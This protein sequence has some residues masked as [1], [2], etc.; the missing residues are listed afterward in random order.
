MTGKRSLITYRASHYRLDEQHRVV[1]VPIL[2]DD[3]LFTWAR[4][5]FGADRHVADTE[6]APGIRV[7]TVFLGLDHRF[8][9][10]GP[11]LVFETMVFDDYEAG[12]CFRYAT[13]DEAVTGHN[14]CVIRLKERVSGPV[15]RADANPA[16]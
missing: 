10:D 13:W 16:V 5:V 8:F 15:E 11:P 4:D 3:D 2:S 14:A 6:V 1:G 12:D 7:S 9:G